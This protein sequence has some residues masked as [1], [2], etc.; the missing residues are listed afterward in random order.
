VTFAVV[1]AGWRAQFFLR[2]A[3]LMP[4]RLR[5]AGVVVRRSEVA[6]EVGRTWAVPAERSLGD[7]LARER[8]D[9]VVSSVSWGANPGVIQAAVAAG[10]PVLAETPP[11]PDAAGLRALWAAVGATGLV[12]IAEQYLMYPGHAAR[13]ELVRRGVVG[14][15]T[16]VQVSSTHLYH[17][18]SMIRGLL[19]VGGGPATVDAREFVAPLADPLTKTGWT[20]DDTPRPAAT[21][22]ATIDFGGGAMGLYDFT[23]NQWHNQLRSRRLVVRGSTGEIVDDEVVRLAGERT[24]LRSPIVRRQIGYDLDLDGYDTDHI[25]FEGHVLFRNEFTGL[26]LADE[27]V[28]LATLLTR[29]AAWCRDEGAPPYP[30]AK[31]CQDHLLGLAI[32]DSVAAGRPVVT[33]VEPWAHSR[34]GTAP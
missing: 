18:V 13:L 16:S 4:D 9:F 7:L 5:V 22:I 25:S 3:A 14:T 1:G 24:I 34:R 26:R 30:L 11:A 20:G 32:G 29:M 17:A 27:D 15:P 23:D 6:E 21:T 12:Q 8:P 31:G 2:L 19:G 33:A 28:A 10:L